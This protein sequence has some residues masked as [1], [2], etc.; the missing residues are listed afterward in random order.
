MKEKNAVDSFYN[1]AEI[2]FQQLAFMGKIA[3]ERLKDWNFHHPPPGRG[4]RANNIIS[5]NVWKL[6]FQPKFVRF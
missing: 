1:W 5:I 2:I 6:G 4:P 3:C